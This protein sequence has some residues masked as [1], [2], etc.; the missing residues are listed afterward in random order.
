MVK[1]LSK[2]IN[3]S[4]ENWAHLREIEKSMTDYQHGMSI[5]RKEGEKRG[6]HKKALEIAK[7]LLNTNLSVQEIAKATNLTVSEIEQLKN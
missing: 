7:N 4:A 2:Q 3:K 6:R 5:S 1:K